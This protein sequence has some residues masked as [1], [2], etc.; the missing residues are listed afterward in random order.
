M[1]VFASALDV[2]HERLV[3]RGEI[4]GRV[5]GRDFLAGRVLEA[6]QPVE[7]A[8]VADGG[9]EFLAV[10]VPPF[11]PEDFILDPQEPTDV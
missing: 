5:E 1:E 3:F 9:I 7:L 10:T 2:F 4:A 11:R 8:G 6:H